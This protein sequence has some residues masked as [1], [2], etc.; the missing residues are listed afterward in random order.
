MKLKEMIERV[1]QHH[2]NM[3]ITEIVRSLNDAQNDM[4]FKTEMV[5]SA[6]Q[7]NTEIG[8]R[9]YKL[10]KHIMRIKSVDYNG[11][12]IKKLLGRPVERDLI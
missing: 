11:K 5:E 10:Q 9:V 8:K 12:S 3:N 6:D 1:Q 4:G 2:P 7:F